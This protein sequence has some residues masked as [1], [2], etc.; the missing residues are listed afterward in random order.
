MNLGTFQYLKS[1]FNAN[2]FEIGLSSRQLAHTERLLWNFLITITFSFS[3]DLVNL[4]MGSSRN[5]RISE[6]G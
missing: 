5:F 3:L 6:L 1:C 2:L 4:G